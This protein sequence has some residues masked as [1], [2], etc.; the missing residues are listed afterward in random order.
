[1]IKNNRI[2]Y[3][4]LLFTIL[5]FSSFVLS[6]CSLDGFFNKFFSFLSLPK[7]D[8]VEITEYTEVEVTSV[9]NTNTN[10]I[11]GLSLN[12]KTL[13]W[14]GE[15]NDEYYVAYYSNNINPT[16]VEINGNS[17]AVSSI[18][19]YNENDIYALRVGSKNEENKIE[20]SPVVYY[21]PLNYTPYTNKVYYFNETLADY[22]ISSQKELNH[23][24]HYAFIYKEEAIQIKLSDAFYGTLSIGTGGFSNG[25]EKALEQAI[26]NSFLETMSLEYS[27]EI[28]STTNKIVKINI[29]YYGAIEPSLTLTKELQQDQSALPYYQTKNF[30]KR[31]ENYNLFHSDDNIR[32]QVVE[33][34]DELFWAVESGATPIFTSTNSS[35]YKI[36]ESAKSILR[37]VISNEMTDSEKLL[38][39]FDFISFNTIYDY[40]ITNFDANNY[41]PHIGTNPVTKYRSFYLEG[42]FYDG[43]AVCDGFSKAFSL[44]ANMEGIKTFRIVGDAGGGHAWNKVYLNEQWYVVDITWTELEM[45]HYETDEP[46]EYLS[47]K[48]F[49]VSDNE[50]KNTHTAHES[51]SNKNFAALKNYYF[52]DNYSYEFNQEEYNLI[53]NTEEKAKNL[54]RA[55]W[56]NYQN[57]GV[58]SIEV[59][60]T[61]PVVNNWSNIVKSVKLEKTFANDVL[62]VPDATMLNNNINYT[63]WQYDNNDNAYG[64]ISIIQIH[65]TFLNLLNN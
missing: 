15:L 26:E 3:N 63:L 62:K 29:N 20:L 2:K 39:I 24:A 27:Y 53:I 36:Y 47:R 9:V 44:L 54:I 21:N 40:Q 52:Y 42:V 31:N 14:T 30:T 16:I 35:A 65:D 4:V 48:Y 25:L 64:T 10:V 12:N 13:S 43:L 56:Y 8:D 19:N 38:S 22:Y 57:D 46:T 7:D 55:L 5:I 37:E 60:I 33:S 51:Q 17:F 61:L 45:Y 1:M 34:S 6:A 59:I 41:N 28:V 18:E 58:T 11:S 32:T 50:I 23:L 49:L